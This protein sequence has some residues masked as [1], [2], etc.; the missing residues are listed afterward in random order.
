M[1]AITPATALDVLTATQATLD[2]D[3]QA[4]FHRGLELV[5][6]YR[7]L[8][9]APYLDTPDWT[10]VAARRIKQHAAE[11]ARAAAAPGGPMT[12]AMDADEAATPEQMCRLA[13][14]QGF[15][16]LVCGGTMKMRWFP[17][18]DPDAFSVGRILN[19]FPHLFAISRLAEH[20][21]TRS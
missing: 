12:R 17:R 13:V 8:Q 7:V 11:D 5:Q 4:A 19:E 9:M 3:S 18:H 15:K 16:C 20:R 14:A 1:N 10:D 6:E 21:R 2:A